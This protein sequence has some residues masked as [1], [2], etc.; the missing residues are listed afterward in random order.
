MDNSNP[1]YYELKNLL[2]QVLSAP[3]EAG[4]LQWVQVPPKDV[5]NPGT[6]SYETMG[7]CNANW[8][9]RITGIF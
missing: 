5:W 1:N 2:S 9:I 3:G 4:A 7:L 6:W 8:L